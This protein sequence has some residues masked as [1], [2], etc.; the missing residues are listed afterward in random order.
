MDFY[1]DAIVKKFNNEDPI[2][3][4]SK[5]WL[6]KHSYDYVFRPIAF[7]RKSRYFMCHPKRNFDQSKIFNILHK[8][9]FID[10]G[11]VV[12]SGYHHLYDKILKQIDVDTLIFTDKKTV[13]EDSIYKTFVQNFDNLE[14]KIN[15]DFDL[16]IFDF[17][18]EVNYDLIK[19]PFNLMINGK[20]ATLPY[21]IV[22]IR[23]LKFKDECLLKNMFGIVFK[24]EINR[25]KIPIFDYR[26]HQEDR[27]DYDENYIPLE[28]IEVL[29]YFS[30][31]IQ[32]KIDTKH[33]ILIIT[34]EKDFA[35]IEFVKRFNQFGVVI[36]RITPKGIV[37]CTFFNSEDIPDYYFE[38]EEIVNEEDKPIYDISEF[39]QNHWIKQEE[40]DLLME[41]SSIVVIDKDELEN[42]NLSNYEFKYVLNTNYIWDLNYRMDFNTSMRNANVE[43]IFVYSGP[44]PTNNR[45]GIDPSKRRVFYNVKGEK[46]I[47]NRYNYIYV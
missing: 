32:E 19:L 7:Q 38:L 6:F 21:I 40:F 39:K 20:I 28:E 15:T 9:K 37:N 17:E 12:L 35:G 8:I 25:N 16:Y 3:L 11:V 24:E 26:L 5:Y 44:I 41:N 47:F 22:F 30:K 33:K 42:F 18:K 14:D 23:N 46:T 1:V 45:R 13:P 31:E 36:H 27:G 29:E 34:D 2:V 43:K 10:R 4:N